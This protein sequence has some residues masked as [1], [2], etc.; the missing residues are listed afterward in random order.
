MKTPSSRSIDVLVIDDDD[1]ETESVLRSLGNCQ[2]MLNCVM[3]EDGMERLA[4]LRGKHPSK[5][6]QSHGRPSGPEHAAHGR[7]GVSDRDTGRCDTAQHCHLCADDLKPGCRPLA[8]L[9]A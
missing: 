9:P 2:I 8:I 5:K 1:M 4:I 3:A 6:G 7:P